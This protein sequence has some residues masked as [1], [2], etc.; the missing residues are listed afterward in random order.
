MPPSTVPVP[1]DPPYSVVS[2]PGALARLPEILREIAPGGRAMLAIDHN[3]PPET[4]AAASD[5]IRAAGY[6]VCQHTLEAHE[7]R[8]T[9]RTFGELIR[10]AAEA[11]LE[12]SDPWIALGGGI[13][14]DVAGFAAAS[15]QRGAPVIQ[16]PTTLLAMVDASVG[17][18]TAVNISLPQARGHDLLLKNYAGAFWQPRAVLA[19]VS[20]L[21]SLPDREMR[22][23]LAECIKHA[24]IDSSEQPELLDWT[25]ENIPAALAFDE[26][27]LQELVARNVAIKAKVVAG[28]EREVDAA[29][30][31][32]ALLN[33]GHTFAHAIEPVGV[34]SLKHGEA[35]SLGMTAAAKTAELMGLLDRD[36]AKRIV[37]AI[38][39]AGLPITVAHLPPSIALIERMRS[40]KKTRAGVLRLV[41]P[42]S[43]G[44]CTVVSSPPIEAIERA[45]DAIRA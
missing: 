27:V 9:L 23:G 6:T 44:G 11:G 29:A 10:A 33:L 7:D 30:G 24:I 32:R 15:Y 17:G 20:T 31:G 38:A 28:D 13:I 5:A 4:V 41:L 1:L 21:A 39:A 2:A 42:V 12:R 45:W 22:C 16:C 40:D 26:S 43:E 37:K 25:V 18:K 3:L 36:Q 8:K 14:G 19:D 35:V 34:L